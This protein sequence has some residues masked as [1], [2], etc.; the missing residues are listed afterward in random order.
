M[1]ETCRQTALTGPD[2]CEEGRTTAKFG[3]SPDS[4]VLSISVGLGLQPPLQMLHSQ[5]EMVIWVNLFL[6]VRL[7][8][9]HLL[10][11]RET[12]SSYPLVILVILPV[13]L[14]TAWKHTWTSSESISWEKTVLRNCRVCDTE[15]A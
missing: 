3:I 4:M 14:P 8:F 5:K 7:R 15:N 12:G 13:M 2:V 6:S 11:N 9:A 10:G 1:A